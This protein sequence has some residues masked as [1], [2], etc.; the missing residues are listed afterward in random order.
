[1]LLATTMSRRSTAEKVLNTCPTICFVV[2][3]LPRIASNWFEFCWSASLVLPSLFLVIYAN[4]TLLRPNLVQVV[5]MEIEL[6]K[7]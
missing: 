5:L 6:L 3:L 4:I 1:M 7:R 2:K